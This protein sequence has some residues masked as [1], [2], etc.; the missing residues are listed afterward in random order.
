M[1]RF[2][3]WRRAARRAKRACFR[4]SS[5]DSGACGIAAPRAGRCGGTGLKP[6]C[7]ATRL[8]PRATEGGAPELPRAQV[9]TT[10]PKLK[11]RTIHVPAGERLQAALDEARPGDRITL[12]PGATYEGPFRLPRKSGDDW[13]L[14]ASSALS[15]LPAGERVRPSDAR[16]MPKLVTSS[17]SVIVADPGAHHYRFAGIEVAPKRRRRSSITSSNW[18][19][20]NRIFHRCRITS[21]STAAT[22]TATRRKGGRRGIAL[23][24]R[25]AAVINSYLSDFKEVG[26]DS[27]AIAGWNGPGPFRIENNY[28]EA[29]GENVMFGGADPSIH[30]LVPADIQVA[31]QSHDEAASL[32][33][34]SPE[35]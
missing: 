10:E 15:Q 34:R 28:L 35:L 20:T 8:K 33:A 30:G 9:D 29:A 7:C 27:Q 12:E 26:A 32:E 16:H 13:I 2:K 31:P 17:R 6:C 21:C 23:N 11:G 18:A 1:E 22:F 14:I 5:D 3:R 25:E 19:M 4:D 24:A